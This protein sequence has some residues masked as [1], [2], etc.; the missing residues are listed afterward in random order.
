MSILPDKIV[1]TITTQKEEFE[2]LAE[3]QR[4]VKRLI[5]DGMTHISKPLAHLDEQQ[6]KAKQQE[7]GGPEC[8]GCIVCDPQQ[9]YSFY[10]KG[11]G[12]SKGK[13]CHHCGAKK[14]T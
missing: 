4:Y 13:G 1:E 6:G 9:L 2:D 14:D 10:R 7:C 5:D 11:K 12:K 3:L 8:V